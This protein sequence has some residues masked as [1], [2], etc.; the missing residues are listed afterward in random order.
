MPFPLRLLVLRDRAAIADIPYSWLG[1]HTQ[2]PVCE[3]SQAR[4]LEGSGISTEVVKGT[5]STHTSLE[6]CQW[7][8]HLLERR[9]AERPMA[10]LP[11]LKFGRKHC[12]GRAGR[13]TLHPSGALSKQAT[14]SAV[15]SHV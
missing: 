10:L 9:G 2:S 7:Q 4:P 6:P 13:P 12:G 14:S 3:F 8:V 5:A 1:S 15:V 11:Q